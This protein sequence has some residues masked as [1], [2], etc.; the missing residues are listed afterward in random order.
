MLR[1]ELKALYNA[2]IW[3]EKYGNLKYLALCFFIIFIFFLIF[4]IVVIPLEFPSF[5]FYILILVIS[6]GIVIINIYIFFLIDLSNSIPFLVRIRKKRTIQEVI[7]RILDDIYS[8]DRVIF[9]YFI[10]TIILITLTSIFKLLFEKNSLT[11]FCVAGIWV[12]LMY[13]PYS[14]RCRS[15]PV[16][17]II[18]CIHLIQLLNLFNIEKNNE[19]SQ[20][21]IKPQNKK[22]LEIVNFELIKIQDESRLLK[23]ISD[24]LSLIANDYLGL[25][26]KNIQQIPMEIYIAMLFLKEKNVRDEIINK[27]KQSIEILEDTRYSD[28]NREYYQLIDKT[29]NGFIHIISSFQI[30]SENLRKSYPNINNFYIYQS[31]MKKFYKRVSLEKLATIIAIITAIFSIFKF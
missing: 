26:I 2:R 16:R 31:L 7:K 23:Y 28:K 29:K 5:Y 22:E 17:A 20:G 8:K 13:I 12:I 30:A 3:K 24:D 10:V 21:D 4:G 9:F 14:V 1:E 15:A 11:Y 18:L 27:L 25:N 19:R 6:V